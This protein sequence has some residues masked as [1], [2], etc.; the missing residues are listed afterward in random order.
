[1]L[2]LAF[3][4]KQA[5]LNPETSIRS[6]PYAV[7]C[8][9]VVNLVSIM[10]LEP[11]QEERSSIR[12]WVHQSLIASLCPVRSN[13]LR[14]CDLA[15]GKQCYCVNE[16]QPGGRSKQFAHRYRHHLLALTFFHIC[17]ES[18]LVARWGKISGARRD[19][20]YEVQV[21]GKILLEPLNFWAAL[22]HTHR[23]SL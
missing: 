1:M 23:S 3:S 18:S 5:S 16:L 11:A 13:E 14:A 6:H 15:W 10:P 21:K 8:S 2:I 12:M 4:S 19:P 20:L 22:A 9:A 17:P 7:P